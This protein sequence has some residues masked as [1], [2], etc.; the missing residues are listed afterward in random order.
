LRFTSDG[1]LHS[2]LSASKELQPRLSETDI[3]HDKEADLSQMKSAI[4][5]RPKKQR[6][7][8]NGT[9]ITVVGN[10]GQST[11]KTKHK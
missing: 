9:A 7:D 10:L 2:C 6:T 4:K 11:I 8:K 5:S 1:M 3:H